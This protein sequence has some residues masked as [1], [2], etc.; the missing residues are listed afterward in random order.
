MKDFHL[1]LPSNVAP[2][3]FP[4]NEPNHFYTPLSKPLYF[5][6]IGWRVAL[7][8]ITYQNSVLSVVDE[9]IEV[10]QDDDNAFEEGCATAQADVVA[11]RLLSPA[12]VKIPFVTELAYN[13]V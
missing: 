8:E 7:K 12:R 3:T 6:G 13:T 9:Y 10:W 5:D 1:V 11:G 2:E 4:N